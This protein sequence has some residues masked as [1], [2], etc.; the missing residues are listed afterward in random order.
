MEQGKLNLST[1]EEELRFSEN[2]LDFKCC[3]AGFLLVRSLSCADLPIA[4]QHKLK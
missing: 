3:I 1:L 2:D 4:A